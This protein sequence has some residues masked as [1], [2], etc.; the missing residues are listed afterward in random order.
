MM[1]TDRKLLGVRGGPARTLTVTS[2]ELGAATGTSLSHL[3]CRTPCYVS[4][5]AVGGDVAARAYR[6]DPCTQSLERV[7]E[8]SRAQLRNLVTLASLAPEPMPPLPKSFLK[9]S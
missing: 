9:E 7:C 6:I 3:P 1:T 8:L 5:A 2:C 4:V